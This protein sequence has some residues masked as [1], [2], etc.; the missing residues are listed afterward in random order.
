MD[1]STT[2]REEC[3]RQQET[4][5]AM[6]AD[7]GLGA[8]A[9]RHPTHPAVQQYLRLGEFIRSGVNYPD[10]IEILREITSAL[11]DRTVWADAPNNQDYWTFIPNKGA[12]KRVQDSLFNPEQFHDTIAEVFFWSWLK[13]QEPS[14][15][16]VEGVG[17]P[18][19]VVYRGTTKE[20]W[21]EVKRVR[22]GKNPKRIHEVIS[23]ANRQIKN[24][25]PE[26]AG[27]VFLSIERAV[28]RVALDDRVPND[29]QP[30]LEEVERKLASGLNRSVGR[31]VVSW[32]DFVV[33]T[34]PGRSISYRFRR[35]SVTLT[36]CQP[37]AR[38]PLPTSNTEIERTI[39]LSVKWPTEA[40]E[41]R[42]GHGLRH[43]LDN[44]VVG[45]GFREFNASWDG[46]RPQ[47]ALEAFSEPD[48]VYRY[49]FRYG[50]GEQ[51]LVTRRVTVTRKAFTMLLVVHPLADGRQEI[52]DAY[53][54][55]DGQ[56]G[57]KALYRHPLVA[58][59]MLISM[60]GVPFLFISPSGPVLI[61]FLRAARVSL[62]NAAPSAVFQLCQLPQGVDTLSGAARIRL[63]QKAPPVGEIE[64]LWF[65]DEKRYR[66]DVRKHILG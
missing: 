59:E 32:D 42:S 54:L 12:Q 5:E 61:K 15:E 28:Q 38:L 65:L 14:A 4:L 13:E 50:G 11:L 34:E 1:F 27:L 60:Y 17:L 36:H 58:F 7:P 40:E 35:R 20:I 51:F 57:T 24:A 55:Y 56:N 45:P 49:Q 63:A 31:V 30:Y 62:P 52:T 3:L 9:K 22:L 37:R 26:K 64:W 41:T 44:V 66:A 25:S 10:E 8:L 23:K 21:L 43:S 47:H 39:D 16:L 2:L 48:A 18:D 53:R 29:I 46:I 33:D 6:F 19:I